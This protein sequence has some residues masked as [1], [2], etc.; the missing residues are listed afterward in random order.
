MNAN[1]SSTTAN[2]TATLIPDGADRIATIGRIEPTVNATADDTAAG[3]SR[4][5]CRA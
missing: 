5:S 3:G 1:A 2:V 4:T